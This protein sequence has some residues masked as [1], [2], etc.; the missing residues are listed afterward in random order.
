MTKSDSNGTSKNVSKP[1][2]FIL[3]L[4]MMIAC[5][6]FVLYTNDIS[7]KNNESDITPKNVPENAIAFLVNE[8]VFSS[9]DYIID[10]YYA[11]INNNSIKEK[12][13][14][15]SLKVES[16]N[17]Q[18]NE[19]NL[20]KISASENTS[21][22]AEDIMD[23]YDLARIEEIDGLAEVEDPVTSIQS[24]DEFKQN[25]TDQTDETESSV[26][27]EKESAVP[28]P[29]ITR[30][31]TDSNAVKIDYHQ[32]QRPV[33]DKPVSTIEYKDASIEEKIPFSTQTRKTLMMKKGKSKL[34]SKGT[35]G[36]KTSLFTS[37]YIDGIWVDKMLMSESVKKE[38]VNQVTLTGSADYDP[39][40][41]FEAP[42]WLYFDDN[43]VPVK[44][45]K[46]VTGSS[47]AYTGGG[48]TA[49]GR[50]AKVGH[51]AV[52]PKEI[53]YGSVLYITSTDNR[54][55][56]GICIAADTGGFAGG[57]TKVDLYFD[58]YNECINYGRRDVKIYVLE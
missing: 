8:H 46:Y 38:A 16:S 56:Y 1:L 36:I 20:Q 2:S 18:I 54:Y 21:S 39:I 9:S 14:D 25:Q 27:E 6:S 24:F 42:S 29:N 12:S 33:I 47:T 48:I 4:V 58:T 57:K 31:E 5:C 49:T 32:E 53:P 35:D 7:L 52:N 26:E 30:D 11:K 44:Y 50:P 41:P 28:I 43:G 13:D 15:E 45:K 34:L 3:S 17:P 37:K 23:T 22:Q 51:V 19:P 40:S 55:N 10:S